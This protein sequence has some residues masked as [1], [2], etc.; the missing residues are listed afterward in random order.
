LKQL[1]LGGLALAES[2]HPGDTQEPS[3][4]PLL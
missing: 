4:S 1:R 2:P 3:P